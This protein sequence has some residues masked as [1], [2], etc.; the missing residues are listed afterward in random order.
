MFIPPASRVPARA[1]GEVWTLRNAI[2][3]MLAA[4]PPN[5]AAIDRQVLAAQVVLVG[6]GAAQEV[7]PALALLDG[8]LQGQRLRK[9]P[10]RQRG[11]IGVVAAVVKQKLVSSVEAKH[12]GS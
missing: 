3:H 5:D 9:Q 4:L 12:R 10:H 11:V 8:L 7:E 6:L 1:S 2:R